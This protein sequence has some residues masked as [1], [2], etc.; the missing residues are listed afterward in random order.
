MALPLLVRRILLELPHNVYVEYWPWLEFDKR[1]TLGAREKFPKLIQ[2]EPIMTDTMAKAVC[3]QIS[4]D[5]IKTVPLLADFLCPVC[6]SI[7]WRPIRLRCKHVVCIRCTIVLQKMQQALCPLCREDVVLEAD[8]GTLMSPCY[9][10]LYLQL[11]LSTV[12][13]GLSNPNTKGTSLIYIS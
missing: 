8:T 11:A 4:Q 5:V 6:P 1:T 13:L 3:A 12:T 10:S 7:C 2:F 9:T